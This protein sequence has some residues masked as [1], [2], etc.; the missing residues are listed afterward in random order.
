MND[1]NNAADANYHPENLSRALHGYPL[2]GTTWKGTGHTSENLQMLTLSLPLSPG[3][4]GFVW[5]Y[6]E[7]LELL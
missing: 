7:G 1:V 2:C 3:T 6:H 5:K 4:F